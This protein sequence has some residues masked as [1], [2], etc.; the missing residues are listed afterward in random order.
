MCTNGLKHDGIADSCIVAVC[1]E[2]LFI[3]AASCGGVVYAPEVQ[4]GAIVA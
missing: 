4:G 3:G 2:H 1:V